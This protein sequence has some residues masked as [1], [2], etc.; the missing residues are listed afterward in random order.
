MDTICIQ[1]KNYWYQTIIIIHESDEMCSN[2]IDENKIELEPVT[3][4]MEKHHSTIT[5]LTDLLKNTEFSNFEEEE[6]S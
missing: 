3:K 5:S 6:V 2:I 1:I 4:W